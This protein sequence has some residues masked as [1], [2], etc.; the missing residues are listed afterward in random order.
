MDK[1]IMQL[2][3]SKGIIGNCDEKFS[4]CMALP[5]LVKLAYYIKPL[6]GLRGFVSEKFLPHKNVYK[7]NAF[8][9]LCKQKTLSPISCGFEVL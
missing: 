1:I 3:F 6:C 4:I 5:I 2:M 7:N 8:F 9:L